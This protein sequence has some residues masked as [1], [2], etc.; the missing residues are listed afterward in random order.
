M[1]IDPP[2]FALESFNP[3]GGWRTHFRSLGHGEPV[4]LEV[5]GQRVRYRIGPES[6]CQRTTCRR[7]EV[8]GFPRVPSAAFA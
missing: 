6:R 5:A 3:I 4:D 2:G 1:M 7:D 8:S